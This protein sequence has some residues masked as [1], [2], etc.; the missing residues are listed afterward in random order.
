[1][2]V[3]TDF[4]KLPPVTGQYWSLFQCSVLG[5][6]GTCDL[7]GSP[8]HRTAAEP[9]RLHAWHLAWGL[10]LPPNAAAMTDC[11][12]AGPCGQN[13]APTTADVAPLASSQPSHAWAYFPSRLRTMRGATLTV[14]NA[15]PRHREPP[16]RRGAASPTRSRQVNARTA[17]P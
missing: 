11:M 7:M 6:G 16:Q 1:M 4:L 9:P 17:I 14:R 15:K 10:S 12:Y 8:I 2:H 13:C 5:T 3:G